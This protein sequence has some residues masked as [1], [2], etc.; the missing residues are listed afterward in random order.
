MDLSL[1][2]SIKTQADAREAAQEWQQLQAERGLSY[3]ELSDMQDTLATL[4]KKFKL[5]NEFKENG[6]I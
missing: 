4:A 2:K 5:T 6:I 1:I 3:S